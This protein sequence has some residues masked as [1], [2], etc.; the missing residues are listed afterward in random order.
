LGE[1]RLFKNYIAICSEIIE[2]LKRGYVETFQHIAENQERPWC[3]YVFKIL[4]IMPHEKKKETPIISFAP[5]QQIQA[6]HSEEEL[7]ED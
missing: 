1:K 4:S 6:Q 7:S 3:R 5:I 2:V